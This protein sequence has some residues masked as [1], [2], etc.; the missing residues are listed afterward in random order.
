MNA[1]KILDLQEKVGDYTR[2]LLLKE[3]LDG[4][5]IQTVEVMVLEAALNA[6]KLILFIGLADQRYAPPTSGAAQ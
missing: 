5:F 3:D 1:K 6:S 2:E 4:V